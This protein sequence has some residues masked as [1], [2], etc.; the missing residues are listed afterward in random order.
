M[1]WYMGRYDESKAYYERTLAIREKA[2]GPDHPE[3][4]SVLMNIA[5]AVRMAGDHE[6]AYPLLER[7]A[8]I[9]EKTRGPNSAHLAN[10]LIELATLYGSHGRHSEAASIYERSLETFRKS[11]GLDHPDVAFSQACYFAVVG[12]RDKAVQ[13]LKHAVD[14]GYRASLRRHPDLDSLHGLPEYEALAARN[15]K[16][17]T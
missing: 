2:L 6:A 13:Y 14:L 1:F 7:A 3:V 16:R 4:A 8:S 12:Q 11:T 9:V 17:E 5:L 10:I 15:D